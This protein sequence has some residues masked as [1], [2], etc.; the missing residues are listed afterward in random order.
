MLKLSYVNLSKGFKSLPNFKND[1][2]GD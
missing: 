1:F 2:V